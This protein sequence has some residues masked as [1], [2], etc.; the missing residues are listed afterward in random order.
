VPFKCCIAHSG[1]RLRS[2]VSV[3][4]PEKYLNDPC[5]ELFARGRGLT[6][7][8]G[9]TPSLAEKTQLPA[10]ADSGQMLWSSRTVPAA[11]LI[12]ESVARAMSGV[13]SLALRAGLSP[14]ATTR[15]FAVQ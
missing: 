13:P 10:F 9:S 3:A 14:I 11:V 12:A 5:L 8:T 1:L 6:G 7:F 15:R 4:R 2:L